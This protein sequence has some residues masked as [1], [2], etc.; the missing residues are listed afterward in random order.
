[1]R[2]ILLAALAGSPALADPISD[3]GYA[4][5]C[6]QA[7]CTIV[8]S[9]F[10]LTAAVEATAPEVWDF[11]AGLD[12]ITAVSFDGE[13][14]ELGDISAPIQVT[15][16][17]T[18]PEDLYQ[19]TLRY[20]QGA[21][22][23]MGEETPFFIQ[24]NGLQWDE[25]VNG[26]VAASFLI[27]ASDGCADGVTPGGIALS[28]IPMGGDPGSAVCW[29]LEYATDTEMDLRDFTGTQGQVTFIRQN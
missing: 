4:L 8:A 19:D 25:V 12:P 21:W 22:K 18:E 20:I 24:I 16:I 11:M 6:D 15:Y 3:R 26:E 2:L 17:K 14:G 5:G 27:Q 13:L 1:M 9:G 28:L 23:P 10:I 7:A 29:Q